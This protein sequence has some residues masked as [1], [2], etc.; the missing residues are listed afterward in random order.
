MQPSIC[1]HMVS[2]FKFELYKSPANSAL[3]FEICHMQDSFEIY[4]GTIN[5]QIN[6]YVYVFPGRCKSVPDWIR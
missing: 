5:N 1:N 6:R 4:Y 2:Y 3:S